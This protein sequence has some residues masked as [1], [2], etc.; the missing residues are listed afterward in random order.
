MAIPQ[1]GEMASP[2]QADAKQNRVEH[3]HRGE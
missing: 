1:L 3:S 2:F